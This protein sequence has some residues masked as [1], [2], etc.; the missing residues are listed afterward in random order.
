[1]VPSLHVP[2]NSELLINCLK[3]EGDK[4]LSFARSLFASKEGAERKIPMHLY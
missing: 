4:Y 2:L 1:M 3:N